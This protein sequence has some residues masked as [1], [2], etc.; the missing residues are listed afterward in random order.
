MFVYLSNIINIY[1]WRNKKCRDLSIDPSSLKCNCFGPLKLECEELEKLPK[2]DLWL[3]ELQSIVYQDI[4]NLTM[5]VA[6]AKMWIGKTVYAGIYKS[7]RHKLAL[8]IAQNHILTI[9]NK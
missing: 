8:M 4:D 6:C 7:A 2:L 1:M 9:C 3:D 5:D